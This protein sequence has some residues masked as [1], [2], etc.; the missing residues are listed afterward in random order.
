M[1]HDAHSALLMIE[2]L[3]AEHSDVRE[4]RAHVVRTHMLE[5]A[6]EDSTATERYRQGHGRTGACRGSATCYASRRYSPARPSSGRNSVNS[7]AGVLGPVAPAGSP[8][9]LPILLR[10]V[11]PVT[12]RPRLIPHL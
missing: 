11:A 4:N 2:Q 6:D 5:S 3:P 1:A 10:A 9:M 7:S 12:A 8:A